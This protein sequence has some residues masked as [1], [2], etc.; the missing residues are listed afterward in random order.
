M[1]KFAYNNAKNTSTRYISFNLNYGYHLHVLYEKNVNLWSKS[2]ST[3]E[4]AIKLKNLITICK[5]SLQYT[6]EL[7]KQYYNKTTKLKN[8]VLSDKVQFN[9]KYIKIKYNSKLEAK[10]FELFQVLY[11]VKKQAYKLEL[12]KRWRIYH[13]FYISLLEQDITKK[14]QVNK[15]SLQLKFDSNSDGKKYKIKAIWD[16]VIYIRKSE[17]YL[18]EF[19]YLVL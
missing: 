18:L 3:D 14:R 10:F 6:Q 7:E 1:T 17:G 16:S 13:I 9:I 2:K 8:N 19:Y 15:V 11:I 4:L 5:K 12:S